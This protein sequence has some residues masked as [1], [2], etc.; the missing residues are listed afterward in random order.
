MTPCNSG[1][2]PTMPVARSALASCAARAASAASAPTMRRDQPRQPL[3]PRAPARP[4]CRASRGTPRSSSFGRKSSSCLLAV[5]VPEEARIRQPRAQ[6]ALVAG[7]DAPRRHPRAA[8]FATSAKR[9]AARPSGVAQR[10]IALVHPHGGAHHLRRQVHEGV[11]D[12]AEQRHRPFHQPRHLVQ[13][14][15]VGHHLQP[16]GGGQRGDAVLDQP[17]RARP[18][19]ATTKR[20]RS[21]ASYSAKDRTAKALGAGAGCGGPRS[22]RRLASPCAVV[23]AMRAGRSAPPRRRAGRGCAAAAAPR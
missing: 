11:V 14:A 3:Q 12:A 21:P 16:L 8:M 1:N 10:E 18:R 20:S 19:R 15:A 2:S 4:G 23:V 22:G 6:H 17:H 7:D 9:G 5:L 13:Q